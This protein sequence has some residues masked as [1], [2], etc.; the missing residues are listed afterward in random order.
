MKKSIFVLAV[1]LINIQLVIAQTFTQTLTPNS[2]D[3][4]SEGKAIDVNNNEEFYIASQVHESLLS[5]TPMTVTKTKT[6]GTEIW[7]KTYNRLLDFHNLNTVNY[8]PTDLKVKHHFGAGKEQIGIVGKELSSSSIQIGDNNLKESIFIAVI[9]PDGTVAW[10]KSFNPALFIESDVAVPAQVGNVS[11]TAADDGWLIAATVR[12]DSY[13]LPLILKLDNTGKVL[14]N[15]LIHNQNNLNAGV[16]TIERSYDMA[17]ILLDCEIRSGYVVDP[18]RFAGVAKI[19]MSNGNIEWIK[20]IHQYSTELWAADLAAASAY[21]EIGD[22]ELDAIIITGNGRDVITNEQSVFVIALN[23]NG[24]I[25]RQHTF[26]P[27]S[28]ATIEAMEVKEIELLSNGNYALVG[29]IVIKSATE[30]YILDEAIFSTIITIHGQIKDQYIYGRDTYMEFVADMIAYDKGFRFAGA[31]VAN[32][33]NNQLSTYVVDAANDGYNA[34]HAY[35]TE[36]LV[37]GISYYAIQTVTDK[38]LPIS[39]QEDPTDLIASIFS[40]SNDICGIFLLDFWKGRQEEEI[41]THLQTAP[42]QAKKLMMHVFPNPSKGTFQVELPEMLV[43]G[44]LELFDESGRSVARRKINGGA[45]TVN[46]SNLPAGS[47]VL[48]V[49]SNEVRET[50][51]IVVQ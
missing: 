8:K 47:Y 50:K 9:Q 48:Y 23:K 14:W 24:Y 15:R 33:G 44:Q 20:Y 26:Y 19:N 46:F 35:D 39:L 51:K 45:S 10:N 3:S 16:V 7:S 1:F 13:T 38:I 31:E 37:D 4:H 5:A 29:E 40:F 2:T 43:E 49:D 22:E 41:G 32:K 12:L 30:F 6:D 34:C 18:N 11:L 17:Y 25:T 21:L 42:H 36:I 28:D 27:S